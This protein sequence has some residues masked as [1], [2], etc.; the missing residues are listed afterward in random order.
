MCCWDK[1]WRTQASGQAVAFEFKDQERRKSIS[2]KDSPLISI[3]TLILI[4]TL[5]IMRRKQRRR[6]VK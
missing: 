4:T 2:Q 3:M 6:N 1:K 5:S